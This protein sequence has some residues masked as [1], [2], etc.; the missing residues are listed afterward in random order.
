LQHVVGFVPS[1]T[2]ILK[3]PGRRVVEGT[4]TSNGNRITL[5]LAAV[6]AVAGFAFSGAAEDIPTSGKPGDADKP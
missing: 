4:M 2:G 1:W 3:D 5:V 6:V